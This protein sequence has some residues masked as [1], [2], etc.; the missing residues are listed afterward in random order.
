LSKSATRV[1]RSC[2]RSCRS[3]TSLRSLGTAA[4]AASSPGY[5]IQPLRGALCSA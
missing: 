3:A 4:R 2:Y 5:E 1:P